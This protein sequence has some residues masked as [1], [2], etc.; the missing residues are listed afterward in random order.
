[1]YLCAHTS[2]SVVG[3]FIYLVM[4]APLRGA[5]GLCLMFLFFLFLFLFLPGVAQRRR[6]S[7]CTYVYLWLCGL[8]SIKRRVRLCHVKILMVD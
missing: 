3:G 7:V 8:I 1:M 6:V 5:A 2:V 4:P